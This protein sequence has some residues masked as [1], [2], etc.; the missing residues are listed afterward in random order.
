M[1]PGRPGPSLL[2]RLV[3]PAAR[4]ARDLKHP[5]CVWTHELDS[6]ADTPGAP[7]YWADTWSRVRAVCDTGE[8]RFLIGADQALSMH[9]WRRY[10]EFWRDAT[11]MLRDDASHADD[12]IRSLR[13]LGVWTEE[14]LSHWA[15]RVVRV[16]M[17]EASSTRIR[18]ALT[19]PEKRKHPID[20]LDDRVLEYIV[21]RGLYTRGA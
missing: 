5:H 17:V 12:L 8:N 13:E 1:G 20:G 7:S 14:D 10:D 4:G 18:T 2:R 21:S 3:R 11:V 19:D 9:K 16:G 6:G 15:S